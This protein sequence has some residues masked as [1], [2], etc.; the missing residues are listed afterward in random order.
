MAFS[1]C[2]QVFIFCDKLKGVNLLQCKGWIELPEIPVVQLEETSS[3]DDEGGE[4]S[5]VPS[6]DGVQND[7]EPNVRNDDTDT[8][9]NNE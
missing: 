2:T 9:T 6:A 4:V 5:D 1:L 3:S 7:N 8:G